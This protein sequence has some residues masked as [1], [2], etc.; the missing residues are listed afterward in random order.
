MNKRNY[1]EASRRIQSRE[2]EVAWAWPCLSVKG[3][4]SG[5]SGKARDGEQSIGKERIASVWV[6]RRMSS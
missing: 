6:I 5:D 2:K 4:D 1:P 3:L